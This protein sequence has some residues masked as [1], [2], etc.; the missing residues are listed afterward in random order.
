MLLDIKE[1]F[2][3]VSFFLCLEEGYSLS[4]SVPFMYVVDF[5]NSKT[6]PSES[7]SQKLNLIVKIGKVA[8]H[9]WP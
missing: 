1:I 9:A 2:L 7:D 3:I 4:S 6:L 5:E 8:H